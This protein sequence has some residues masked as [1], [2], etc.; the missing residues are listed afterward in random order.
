MTVL[1]TVVSLAG[2]ARYVAAAALLFCFVSF[3]SRSNAQAYVSVS[4]AYPSTDITAAVTSLSIQ[5]TAPGEGACASYSVSGG[6]VPGPGSLLVV[7]DSIGVQTPPFYSACGYNLLWFAADGMKLH[8]IIPRINEIVAAA[9]PRVIV[10]A[11]GKN[12]AGN[13]PLSVWQQDAFWAPVYFEDATNSVLGTTVKPVLLDI[14][15]P[16]RPAPAPWGDLSLLAAFNGYLISNPPAAGSNVAAAFG[17][18][19]I[20]FSNPP[21]GVSAIATDGGYLTPGFTYPGDGLYIH[22]IGSGI[23]RMW[24]YVQAAVAQGLAQI[25]VSCNDVAPPKA[26]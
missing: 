24:P 9:R 2:C 4:A 21:P 12:D 19:F 6:C 26:P 10:L 18:N 13:L 1:R 22:P 11:L 20:D 14:M 8:D 5:A 25:G 7:W 16:E 17:L 23:T 3:A 15:P